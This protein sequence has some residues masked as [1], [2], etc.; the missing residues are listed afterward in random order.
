MVFTLSSLLFI[1]EVIRYIRGDADV[2][3]ALVVAAFSISPIFTFILIASIQGAIPV[4]FVA[5][6]GAICVKVS[7]H[8]KDSNTDPFADVSS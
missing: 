4:P 6:V 5:I 8:F 2:V 3:E 1:P 7:N